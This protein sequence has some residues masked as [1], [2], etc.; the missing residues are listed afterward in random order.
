MAVAEDDPYVEELLVTRAGAQLPPPARV[1]RVEIALGA[2]L[3]VAVAALAGWR[4]RCATC[5]SSAPP[6]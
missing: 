6:A 1:L 5:R 2:L 4:H 3:I